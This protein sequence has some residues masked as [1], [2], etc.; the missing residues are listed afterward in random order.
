MSATPR[1]SL[2]FLDVGQTNKELT[3]NEAL[4]TLDILVGALVESPPLADPPG[5]PLVGSAYIVAANPS[6]AWAGMAQSI[7]AWTSGGWRFVKPAEGLMVFVRSAGLFALFRQNTWE[8]G[9]SRAAALVIA[10][11]QVVG[12][13]AAAIAGPSGGTIVDQE[14]RGT[15]AAILGA[16]RQHG[17]IES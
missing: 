8:Q 12:P 2:P 17:L 3:H 6:G 14:A 5:A 13:R 11:Q 1:F 16:L 7:A 4:Q 10:D 9:I 15:I